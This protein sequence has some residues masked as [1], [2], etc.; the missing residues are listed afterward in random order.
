MTDRM[1]IY[2]PRHRDASAARI[3]K[4]VLVLIVP[5]ALLSGISIVL[6]SGTG[7]LP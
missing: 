5:V 2:S 6:F 1:V 7:M 4:Q 3:V